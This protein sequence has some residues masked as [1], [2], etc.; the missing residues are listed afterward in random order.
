MLSMPCSSKVILLSLWSFS[1]VLFNSLWTEKFPLLIL[2]CWNVGYM[3]DWQCVGLAGTTFRYAFQ[4]LFRSR[5]PFSPACLSI[6]LILSFSGLPCLLQNIP[7]SPL[8]KVRS[9]VCDRF[10]RSGCSPH[11][12]VHTKRPMNT[13]RHRQT[14]IHSQRQTDTQ[15]EID[16]DLKRDTDKQLQQPSDSLTHHT[17]T[18]G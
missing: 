16:T 17:D 8:A 11:T 15:T 18:H 9:D 10:S 5:G 12:T 7:L 4:A 6:P 3:E 14:D 1:E 13:E 2:L